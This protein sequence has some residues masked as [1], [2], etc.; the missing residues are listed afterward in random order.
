M[1]APDKRK[2]LPA[3]RRKKVEE[4][5]ASWVSLE[6]P[7]D[8]RSLPLVIRPALDGI[9]LPEW[10]AQNRSFLRTKLNQH[11]G[12]LFRGFGLQGADDLQQFTDAACDGPLPYQERS[13]PRSAV[14]GN[15]YTSTDYPPEYKIFLH[16]EQSYNLNFPRY[17]LFLCVTA[18]K[19]GGATPIADSRRVFQRIDPAVRQRFIDRK[20]MYV[21]NFS[22]R[23]GLTWQAAF[24]TTERAVVEDYCRSNQISWE[25]KPGD[26]LRTRQVREVTAL[27]PDTGEPVWFNHAT[28]FHVSTLED[29]VKQALL[30]EMD[31]IDLPNNTYYGD[32]EEIEPEVLEMLRRAY[33]EELVAE[34]W[35]EGD[36]LMLD[37]MLA[38]HGRS[39]FVGPRLILTAMASPYDWRSLQLHGE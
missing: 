37:N 23:F 36:L 24:Q 9:N 20:Y 3:T 16:N 34:T 19:Q 2:K 39:S 11:G 32:G 5:S 30:S 15:I 33:L 12:I 17:I 28:F 27:H 18:A 6:P 31:A 10:A 7:E 35:Q 29:A 14:Q 26:E 22:D 13:S 1:E 4:S 38:A 8:G 25:W 21:R